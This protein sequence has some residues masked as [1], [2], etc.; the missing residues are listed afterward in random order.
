MSAPLDRDE[1]PPCTMTVDEFCAHIRETFGRRDVR[2]CAFR[3][4][5]VFKHSTLTT[6]RGELRGMRANKNQREACEEAMRAA[7]E[8]SV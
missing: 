2:I 1:Y 7:G 5:G 8:G 6:K 4:R 3:V